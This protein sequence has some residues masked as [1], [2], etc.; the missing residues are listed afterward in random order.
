MYVCGRIRCHVGAVL[1]RFLRAFSSAACDDQLRVATLSGTW[2]WYECRDNEG[3]KK[4][5]CTDS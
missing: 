4:V 3:S 2:L 5:E 1:T